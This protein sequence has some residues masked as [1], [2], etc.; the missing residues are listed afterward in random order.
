[1]FGVNGEEYSQAKKPD[2]GPECIAA[3]HIVVLAQWHK[4]CCNTGAAGH[5]HI[6]VTE[7]SESAAAASFT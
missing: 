6:H 3:L 1:M 2:R 7:R 4:R 5:T